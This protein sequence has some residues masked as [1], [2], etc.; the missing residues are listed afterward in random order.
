MPQRRDPRHLCADPKCR[1]PSSS[2]D[3]HAL[4]VLPDDCTLRDLDSVVEH[5]SHGTMKNWSASDRELVGVR[6][7]HR[8]IFTP[9]SVVETIS[10]HSHNDTHLHFMF[11]RRPVFDEMNRQ[12]LA[13]AR[14]ARQ[15]R[16]G[17][18]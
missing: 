17:A 3:V 8:K 1:K 16:R 9:E 13:D 15:R 14:A 2:P 7:G 4:Y 10:K 6:I 12:E 11:V 18:A 5:F